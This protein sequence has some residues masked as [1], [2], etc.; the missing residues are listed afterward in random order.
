MKC[1]HNDA[2]KQDDQIGIRTH[3]QVTGTHDNPPIEGIGKS[4]QNQGG[5]NIGHKQIRA[6]NGRDGMA[7]LKSGKNPLD[8]EHQ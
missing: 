1:D 8:H 6:V 2:G 3:G 5:Q 4:H 7:G